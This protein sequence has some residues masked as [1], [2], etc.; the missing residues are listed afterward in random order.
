MSEI[1]KSIELLVV[2]TIEK[3]HKLGDQ[4]GGSGHLSYFTYQKTILVD[5]DLTMV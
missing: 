3:E 5:R 1:D 2:Q 4:A